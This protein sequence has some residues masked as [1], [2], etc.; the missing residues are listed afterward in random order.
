MLPGVLKYRLGPFLLASQ[1][2][3]PEFEPLAA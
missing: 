3:L 1:V 2:P